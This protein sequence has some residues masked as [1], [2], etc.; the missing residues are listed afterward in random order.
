MA[1]EQVEGKEI[2]PAADIYA[3]GV[4]LFEMMTGA[5][6]FKGDTTLAVIFKRLNEPPPPPRT[7][8][9]EL[10]QQWEDVIL[11][12][13]ARHPVGRFAKAMDVLK[14]LHHEAPI[15][16]PVLEEVSLPAPSRHWLR[17]A[18]LTAVCLLLLV[19]SWAVTNRFTGRAPAQPEVVRLLVADFNNQTA[20]PLLDGVLEPLFTV[21][22]EGASFINCYERGQAR[23]V[24]AQLQSGATGLSEALARLV[25]VREGVNVILSG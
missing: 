21:A 19:L 9:P 16:K 10:N 6:P 5:L 15:V 14:A 4:V 2:T 3:L 25:A 23:K 8:V 24:A 13:L 20:E 17:P 7:L 22:L 12:C 11:C 1:P 18:L